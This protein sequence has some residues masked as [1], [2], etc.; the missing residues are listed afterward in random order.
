[1]IIYIVVIIAVFLAVLL[2]KIH[3]L[4]LVQVRSPWHPLSLKIVSF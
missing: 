2:K 3:G 4:I 1:M